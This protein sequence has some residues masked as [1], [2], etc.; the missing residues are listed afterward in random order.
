MHEIIEEYGGLILQFIQAVACIAFI[1]LIFGR[2]P[3]GEFVADNLIQPII[4]KQVTQETDVNDL[5]TLITVSKTIASRDEPVVYTKGLI[6][7][8]T[9]LKTGVEYTVDDIVYG[10]DADGNYFD[11]SGNTYSDE[12]MS[13]LIKHSN[14]SYIR[15]LGLY[16]TDSNAI[17]YD[18]YNKYESSDG[19]HLSIYNESEDSLTGYIKNPEYDGT[20]ESNEYNEVAK[21]YRNTNKI[22]FTRAGAYSLKVKAVDVE[23][24]ACVVYLHISIQNGDAI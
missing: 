22:K 9:D 15:I 2:T 6:S 16:D 12:A 24:K 11:M 4:N 20:S 5:D 14:E 21:Y 3:A 23:G 19:S 17:I 8:S 1:T 13:V 18:T 7:D 10:V